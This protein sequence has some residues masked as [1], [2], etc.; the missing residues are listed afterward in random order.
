MPPATSY[1]KHNLVSDGTIAAAHTDP[2]LVNAWGLVINPAPGGFWWV[3]DNGTGLSTLYDNDGVPQSL[4]VTIPP[5][6]G[7]SDSAAPTGIVFNSG[8]AFA[9]TQGGAS[10]SSAFIYCTEDGTISG[11][12]PAV[13]PPAPSK[14]AVIAV[15]NSS[16]GAIY[17]GLALSG[18][19][20]GQ[21][22]YVADFHNAHIDVFDSSF[23]PVALAAA[24]FTDANLPAGFAPFNVAAI[25][26][27]L[28]VAYAKQDEDAEDDEPGAG[29]G[30]IDVYDQNGMFLNR[31][32][33]GGVLN[34]P[35]AMVEATGQFGFFSGALLVGNFADGRINGFDINTGASFG[36][37]SDAN[38]APIECEGLWGLAFGTGSA[39]NDLFFASGPA[40][41]Q[42]GVFGRITVVEPEPTPPRGFCAVG[43]TGA[44]EA[45][46]VGLLGMS[47]ISRRRTRRTAR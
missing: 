29:N 12:S 42:H 13:P 46:F 43:T 23:G 34:S 27:K 9:V 4:V 35:W 3:S 1:E 41:E 44:V 33:S 17:K 5:P 30:F 20:A 39:S 22:L 38:G 47:F 36:P 21:R 7:S 8:G 37:V 16:K 19:G 24:A 2:N 10:G 18:S 28:Y 40:G 32:V 15:D 31:L 14:Q 11:W 6:P 26:D 25:D 45:T